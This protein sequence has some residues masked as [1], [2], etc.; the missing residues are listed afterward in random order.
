MVTRRREGGKVGSRSVRDSTTPRETEGLDER[1]VA[2]PLALFGLLIVTLLVTSGL[3]TATTELALSRAH[4]NGVLGLYTADAVVEEFVA[5][6][7]A[8]TEDPGGSL[9]SGTF[10]IEI[11]GMNYSVRVAELHRGAPRSLSD[12]SFERGATYA[13]VAVPEGR[14]GRSV[15]AMVDAIRT[16]PKISF[17]VEAG[18]TVGANATVGGGG[19]VSDGSNSGA[20]CD[21]ASASAAIHHPGGTTFTLEGGTL[22]IVGSVM[23][24]ERDAAELMGDILHEYRVEELAR[25]AEIR[26]GPM[27][28]RDSFS[29]AFG[30][31]FNAIDAAYRWGCPS[32]LISTCPR[33]QKVPYTSVAID[34]NGGTVEISGGHGQGFLVIRNGDLNI[35]GD[36]SYGGVIVVEGSL[37]IAST[38]RLEGAVI[39]LGDD[40]VIAP[41]DNAPTDGGSV[42]RFNRCLIAEAQ[43]KLTIDSLDRTPQAI[44]SPTYAWYEVVR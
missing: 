31:R 23:E 13:V 29:S 42:I 41:S 32:Q 44:P 3:S 33:E 12:G 25:Y 17:D 19:T 38:P 9:A 36:F 40:A 2:L 18:L 6:R 16:A 28:S 8:T 34:A 43:R 14:A 22:E 27:Y 35:G 1:G 15:G 5:S 30:P 10:P 7:A 4:Q 24:D 39:A 21:S 26:F 11:E 20:A 37:R